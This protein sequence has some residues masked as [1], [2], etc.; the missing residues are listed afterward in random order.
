M[1]PVPL[2]KH[3]YYEKQS[4]VFDLWS[5]PP[6]RVCILLSAVSDIFL[7]SVELANSLLLTCVDFFL[8]A[9]DSVWV[10]LALTSDVRNFGGN[11]L[12]FFLP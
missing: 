10:G 11:K 2:Y 8:R 4:Q 12:L 5:K 3:M 7:P 1:T 6:E 9:V